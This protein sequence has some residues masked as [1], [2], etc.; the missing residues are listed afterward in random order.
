FLQS[1]SLLTCMENSLVWAT[2]FHVVYFPDN[3]TVLIN[4]AAMTTINNVRAG[5]QVDLITYGIN[6]LQRNMSVCDFSQYKQLCPLTSGHLD[7]EF[8]IQLSE[9]IDKMI[10]PIAYTI[11]DLDARVKMMIYNLDNFENLAC[12]EATVSN[13]KTVQTK[14]AAWPIAVTSGLG[15][16][17]SGV[18]SIIGHS[19]TAAHIAANSMSLFIYFQ[20]LAVTAMLGV[21]RVPPIAAAWAQNF[22]W[23]MGII[24]MG[25]VQKMANWYLQGTGGTPTHVLS[26]KYL[27]VSVQKLKRGLQA[28][29][30]AIL[31]NKRLAIAAGTDI[32]LNSDKLNSTLYTTNE[33]EA[34]TSNKV[35]ILRGIQR[36]AYLT[37]IEITS[38]F[39]TSIAFFVFIAFVLLAALSFFNALIVICIRSNIMNEGKFNQF[40]QHWGSVI[41]GSLYRL[42]LVAFPQLVVMCVWEFTRRDSA[43]IVVV[44]FFFFAISLALMM[45]SAVRVFMTGRRS[46]REHKNP[47]YFLYGDEL[48]LSKFGF[49]Y[50]QYRADCY[51]FL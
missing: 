10:P 2:N 44:A 3:R 40:R 35:L 49:V 36:V 47:A 14:Y 46:V 48:F 34:E 11:P 43:G 12:I 50:V 37:G 8:Q 4:I 25:F 31:L 45:Y 41:K 27:S 18:V 22:M 32:F 28:A 24:K 38:L 20:S 23:S 33:R 39:I 19:S 1:N 5:I 13:G 51:Y 30:S 21:A 9:D 17:T 6:A 29:G 26:N 42:V 16:I 15:L 7:I